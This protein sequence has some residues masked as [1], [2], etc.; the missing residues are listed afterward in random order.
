[1]GVIFE[2][3]LKRA[4]NDYDNN[5]I[6]N[7]PSTVLFF[8]AL[9]VGVVIASLF[10]F[11]T[12]RYFVRQRYG[13]HVFPI[14]QRGVLLSNIS[15]SNLNPGDTTN[16]DLRRQLEYIR[17]NNFV[18]QDVVNRIFI[19]RRRRGRRRG[20]RYSRMKKLTQQQVNILFPV[21]TYYDWKN[22]GQERDHSLRDGVLHEEGGIFSGKNNETNDVVEINDNQAVQLDMVSS[23][24]TDYSAG[25]SITV[26]DSSVLD[27]TK[28]VEMKDLGT[29]K[30]SELHEELHFSS[31]TCA[32]CLE[33]IEDDD[34][35]RGLI[36]GHVFHSECLDPWLTKRRACCPM[37]KR[38]YFYKDETNNS[39]NNTNNNTEIGTRDVEHDN[40]N[41]HV[42][43]N[44]DRGVVESPGSNNNETDG[45]ANGN[46]HN[47]NSYTEHDNAGDEDSV[48][49]EA[50]RNDPIIA[51]MVQDL[52]PVR[53]RARMILN[54][55]NMAEYQIEDKANRIAQKKYSNCVKA[56][57]WRTMGI[58]QEDFFS[59]AVLVIY[60]QVR[61]LSGQQETEGTGNGNSSNVDHA[62]DSE[63]SEV[64]ILEQNNRDRRNLVEQMV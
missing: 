61:P 35:V 62:P 44:T 18:R 59:W 15:V 41:A 58:S 33:V 3:V 48:D 50:L 16:E 9:A 22:G 46:E 26:R 29:D 53:E 8:L 60:K 38:D 13:L 27:E 12:L 7:T 34:L 19:S 2:V 64:D 28:S 10:V 4:S 20:G 54:D 17:E 56:L 30:V 51:S 39:R 55:P 49:L 24:T 23:D 6:G 31:G 57:W 47:D 42:D 5:F 52:I 63:I 11:F 25:N 14:G 36:C 43:A 40:D 1:M 45:N 32:I 37:C 21:K